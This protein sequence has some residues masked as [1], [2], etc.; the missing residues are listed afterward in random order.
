MNSFFHDLKFAARLLLKNRGFAIVVVLTLA[1]GIGANTTVFTIVNAVL[2]ANLPVERPEQIVAVWN[3]NLAKKQE[4]V[5]MSF[6]DFADFQSQAKSFK[7]LSLFTFYQMTISDPDRAPEQQPGARMSW[8]AFSLL[9]VR[10]ILGR[11]FLPKDDVPGAPSVA[12]IGYT[13]WQNRYAGDPNILGKTIRINEDSKTIVG[14]MPQGM[15]FPYEA[16]LW[17]PIRLNQTFRNTRDMRGYPVFGR[18]ADGVTLAQAQSE[19]VLLAKRLQQ[20]YPD[21]NNGIGAVVQSYNETFLSSST[22]LLLLA[23]LGAV[24]FVLL[25]ACA[26]VANLLLSRSLTR[27]R[28]VAIRSAL[29]AGRVR[30]VQQLL[31][32]SILL[33]LLGGLA[34]FLISVW[35]VRLFLRAFPPQ[36]RLPYWFN[37][38]P[39]YRVF[40]YL[41]AVCLVTS[42]LFGLVPALHAS[43]VDLNQALKDGTRGSAGGRRTLLAGSLVVS[44]VALALVLLTGAGLMIRSFLKQYEMSSTMENN[45]VLTLTINL[46]GAKYN[47]PKNPQDV[48]AFFNRLQ[49]ELPT[50]GGADTVALGTDLPLSWSYDWTLELEGHPITDPKQLPA[51]DGIVISPEYFRVLGMPLLRG[52]YFSESD[53]TQAPPVAIVNNRLASKYWPGENPIGKRLRITMQQ[54]LPG[55]Q[56]KENRWLT[57]VGV[58]PDVAQRSVRSPSKPEI[59]SMVYIPF[60]QAPPQ[61]YIV[62]L[63]LARGGDAHTLIAPARAMIQRVNPDVTISDV[64][65][66]P[67]YFALSRTESRL[68]GSLFLVF[69]MIGLLL[70]SV[71][72]YAVMANSVNQRTQEIGI[73]MALGAEHNAIVR[74]VGGRGIRLAGIGVMIGLAASFGVTRVMASLLYGI[75]ATDSATFALVAVLLLVVAALACYIPARRATRIDPLV[76]LRTE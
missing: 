42:I 17:F 59:D 51:V 44:E 9:G 13:L 26:N 75:S 21:K 22:R 60:R 20:Q 16:V 12:I 46:L 25:I 18:L 34:G 7:G 53:G 49:P 76:A 32:E 1:L 71:G 58:A 27:T 24:A 55:D 14:V 15:K 64:L 45:K 67:E 19:V 28:E 11:D 4:R 8:N 31:I 68:F 33:G 23:L 73:R 56:P 72:I 54:V 37:F 62:V 6:P 74:L 35:G 36:W 47:D 70:A 29:G 39:D 66:L 63:A 69:A 38:S 2:L 57:V 41:A 50:I 5:G 30:I 43:K 65:T 3:N 40:T 10:P 52:R 48:I 61:R